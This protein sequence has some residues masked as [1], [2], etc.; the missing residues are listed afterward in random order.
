MNHN[1]E[2]FS[3]YR[4]IYCRSK[5]RNPSS[6]RV[7]TSLSLSHIIYSNS[8]LRTR[9]LSV[10]A[11]VPCSLNRASLDHWSRRLPTT[12]LCKYGQ[13]TI[14]TYPLVWRPVLLSLIVL[15][16][17]LL[18]PSPRFPD[19]RRSNGLLLLGLFGLHRTV[20]AGSISLAFSKTPHRL[21][22]AEVH[23][24]KG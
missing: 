14:I 24:T 18:S 7:S 19:T 9:V 2:Q 6:A 23:W 15:V 10:L 5:T 8:P 1:I 4:L 17:Y 20:P 3:L 11:T 22:R 21:C 12:S 16:G 13:I